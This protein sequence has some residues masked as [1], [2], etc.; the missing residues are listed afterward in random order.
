MYEQVMPALEAFLS[1]PSPLYLFFG[2][3]VGILFGIL[4]G[5]GGPQALA[6]LTP[7]TFKMD[8]SSAIALLIGAMSAIPL[9]GS[10]AA[11][12][13]NL[14]GHAPSV[15][16]SFDGY[17]LTLQ[18][19]GGQAVGASAASALFSSIFG[20]IVLTLILPF[21]EKVVLAFSYPEFFMMALAGLT[22]IVT[23]SRKGS[24][25]KGMITALVG[26]ML[27]FFGTDPN[28]AISRFS[29]GS[30]YLYNGIQ[31]VPA[32]IGLFAVGEGLSMLHEKGTIAPSGLTKSTKLTGAVQGIKSI[33]SHFGVFI[34]SSLIGTIMGMI[35]GVGGA[36][37]TIVAYGQAVQ[38]SKHPERY[39]KGEIA[40]VIAPEAAN[41]SKDAS[42]FIPS[43]IFGI[44]SHVEMV[45][46]I[47]S[48]TIL[49]IQ[50]G[51]K[52]MQTDPGKVLEI[53]YALVA[54]NILTAILAL[55]VGG[56]L[57]RLALISK[58]LLAPLIMAVSLVGAYALNGEIDD[59]VLAL[60]FG[61]LGHVMD[62]FE[63]PKINL[64]IPLM[65]GSLI[66]T[67]FH[68][69]VLAKGWMG[70]I[71]R[72]ISLGML[73]L[74]VLNLVFTLRKIHRKQ[75]PVVNINV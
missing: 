71:N 19:K 49:G 2:V 24:M 27:A 14:P 23:I 44:P 34:R 26:L 60:V 21:G 69:T 6:L 9:S 5:L 73:I 52:L 33:F 62:R 31:I 29:F 42:G 40:G 36:I 35:P 12:L 22:M 3:L 56:Y 57:T 4:P 70:F 50:P 20:A 11:I 41:N 64:V 54:G 72:P 8:H 58:Q 66:E 16:S 68:Q 1:W 59:V 45:V 17:P 75:N 46:L 13:L 32:L 10:L 37:T 55:F 30:L 18:G 15:A 43:L 25:W 67:S 61:I 38:T 74:I 63:F 28:T 51:P 53:I 47:G 48:L 7:L 65:V 39:G